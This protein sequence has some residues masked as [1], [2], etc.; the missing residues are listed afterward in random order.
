MDRKSLK[1]ESQWQWVAPERKRKKCLTAAGSKILLISVT[2]WVTYDYASPSGCC[3]HHGCRHSRKSNIMC[4]PRG[5]DTAPV[6][7]KEREK[8]KLR[9]STTLGVKQADVSRAAVASLNILRHFL[10]QMAESVTIKAPEQ[11]LKSA[12][13]YP[14]LPQRVDRFK[15]RI[16]APPEK[17]LFWKLLKMITCLYEIKPCLMQLSIWN[18]NMQM[19]EQ[20][21]NF[22]CFSH[23]RLHER[24][25][26]FRPALSAFDFQRLL[27][28][29]TA[30]KISNAG[31][32]NCKFASDCIRDQGRPQ[33]QDARRTIL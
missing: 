6:V 5:A 9:A 2:H 32:H 3:F 29:L 15:W 33:L 30:L 23:R 26:R 17:F 4:P 21:S 16:L 1:V 27:Y 28:N 22:W 31:G 20:W 12:R 24:E 8:K 11:V 19:I 7:K 14:I 25:P 18:W 13:S 10:Q